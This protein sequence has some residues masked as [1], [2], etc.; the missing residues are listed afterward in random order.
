MYNQSICKVFFLL[1]S[2]SMNSPI[3]ALDHLRLAVADIHASTA[4]YRILLGREP[5]WQGVINSHPATLFTTSNLALLLQESQGPVGLE[6]ACFR[7]DDLGRLQRRLERV[8]IDTTH[9][10]PPIPMTT[11]AEDSSGIQVV[12]PSQCRGLPLSFTAAGPAADPQG[13]QDTAAAS[14]LDHV[15]IATGDA[16]GTAF[17]LAAQLGLDM[18]LDI[19][20]PQWDARLMFFR[21]GDLI[22]EVFQQLS[23]ESAPMQD[24]FYGLSWRVADA[25]AARTRLSDHGFEVSDVREG[26]R[27]GSRVLTVRNRT[28]DVATLLIENTR[29]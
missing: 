13:M 12:N 9:A 6:G 18:R 27:P 3:I 8:G 16:Q 11:G 29:S 20:R 28:A 5:L 25:D 19:N 17:M 14:G 2:R 22:V 23:N 15:V 21:C 7:V 1:G 10:S 24:S 26:R 4:D